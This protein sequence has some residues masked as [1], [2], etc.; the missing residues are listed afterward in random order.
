MFIKHLFSFESSIL[1]TIDGPVVKTAKV[2]LGTVVVSDAGEKVGVSFCRQGSS[3]DRFTRKDGVELAADRALTGE[4]VKTPNR[5]VCSSWG[6]PQ[7]LSSLVEQTIEEL[8]G[9]TV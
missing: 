2:P 7:T 8:K 3:P 4:T 5:K 1:E 6:L 9:R